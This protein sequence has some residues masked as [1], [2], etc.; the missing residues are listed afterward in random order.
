MEQREP[1]ACIDMVTFGDKP[2][3]FNRALNRKVRD[4]QENGLDV[5]IQYQTSGVS[6]PKFI[7]ADIIYSA[8]LIGRKRKE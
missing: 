5:E 1:I 8:L 2:D 6:N 7:Q 4:M 3:E